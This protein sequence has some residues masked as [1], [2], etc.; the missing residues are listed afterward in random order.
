MN[1]DLLLGMLSLL[2]YPVEVIKIY[3][4][5]LGVTGLSIGNNAIVT[6]GL[7]V[8]LMGSILNGVRVRAMGY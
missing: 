4:I 5:M 3:G 7:L 1:K 2:K 8:W 6:N